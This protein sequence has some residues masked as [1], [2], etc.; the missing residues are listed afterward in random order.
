MTVT[1]PHRPC[2][3]SALQA[4]ESEQQRR[5]QRRK[6]GFLAAGLAPFAPC[7]HHQGD[8]QHADRHRQV[9]VDHLDPCLHDRHRSGRHRGFGGADVRMRPH[10]VGLAV[11]A[12]PIRA[13]EAGVGQPGEGA[14]HD[15]VE[16]QEQG[17]PYQFAVFVRVVGY[18]DDR[19]RQHGRDH[20]D[21]GKLDQHGGCS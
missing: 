19:Q 5:E 15:Q 9:A 17:D 20:P 8:N 2:A 3:E 6:P 14:E 11:A 13:A 10:R 7:D 21:D 4:D 1:G 18:P 16:R 12:R